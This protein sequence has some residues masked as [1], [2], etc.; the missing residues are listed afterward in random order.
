[1]YM[2]DHCFVLKDQKVHLFAPLGKIG[3]SWEDVG[4]EET[5]EHMV[6]SDLV[7]WIHLGTAVPASGRDGYFDKMMGGIAPMVIENDGKF[8]MFYSGWTFTSKR[9]NFNLTG[10]R[11]SIGLA[12]SNDLNHWEKPEEFAINGLGVSGTDPCVVRDD[13]QS[14]W[15][16]YTCSNDVSVFTSKDLLHWSAAGIALS[17]SDMKGSKSSG[18]PAESP[19]VMKHPNSGKWMIITNGGYSMSENPFRF[20]PI[21]PYT[22]K[23]GWH[24]H[25]AGVTA[26]GNWGDGTNC[27]ADDD[28]AGFAHEV[29]EF[30][31]R[32]YLTGVVGRDGQ[33]KLK[34]TPI[35]WTAD[36]FRLAQ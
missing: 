21:Q 27:Q 14:R 1:M 20:P 9:P 10:S 22:F 26:S 29:L 13:L 23:A 12:I 8:F 2:K 24:G 5:A 3:T 16:M 11:H 18:N 30:S 34:F 7:Q 32:W 36:S 25:I 35:E 4:S 19:F 15:L 6:S 17:A 31:G 33:F 28:G